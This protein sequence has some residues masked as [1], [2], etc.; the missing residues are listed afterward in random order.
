MSSPKSYS[1]W[2]VLD[3]IGQL[4][5]GDGIAGTSFGEKRI[6]DMN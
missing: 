4:L 2:N 3:E 6:Y 1:S 5:G